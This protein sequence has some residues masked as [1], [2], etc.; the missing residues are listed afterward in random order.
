MTQLPYQVVRSRIEPL[1]KLLANLRRVWSY[2]P[3][4]LSV[5][6]NLS[7]PCTMAFHIPKSIPSSPTPCTFPHPSFLPHNLHY[8]HYYYRTRF[9]PISRRKLLRPQLHISNSSKSANSISDEDS[10]NNRQDSVEYVE[11][12]GIGSRKDAILDFCLNS[13][14]LSPA[15]RF[16]NIV[17]KDSTKV[18]LQQRLS[19]QGLFFELSG[20]LTLIHMHINYREFFDFFDSLEMIE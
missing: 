1:P 6:P 11:V 20:P 15:L 18:Q 2:R 3:A 7:N 16:W 17:V 8:S 14:F 19:N 12:F 9:T 10:K 13:P 5:F 4:E